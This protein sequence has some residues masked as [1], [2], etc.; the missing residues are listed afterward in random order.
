MVKF[1]PFPAFDAFVAIGLSASAFILD[2][3]VGDVV[4]YALP[5]NG[6][7]FGALQNRMYK[8]WS[9]VLDI[10]IW[11]VSGII[12]FFCAVCVPVKR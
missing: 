6:S 9:S 11:V 12:S 10:I 8:P 7:L 3:P 5:V 4:Q 1:P 2:F